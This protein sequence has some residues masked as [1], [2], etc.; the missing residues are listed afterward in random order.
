MIFRQKTSQLKWKRHFQE[1]LSIDTHSTAT[2]PPLVILKKIKFFF[3]KTHNF[4]F[5]KPP[6]F[7]RFEKSYYFRR[8]LRQ[9]CYNSV[10]KITVRK[11][12]IISN[13]GH[14]QLANIGLK[15]RSRWVDAFPSM[16]EM[17]AENNKKVGT[18]QIG[19]IWKAE[20]TRS[21]GRITKICFYIS[22]VWITALKA[23]MRK[24]PKTRKWLFSIFTEFGTLKL[25]FAWAKIYISA[26]VV[27]FINLV[28]LYYSF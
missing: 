19:E 8:I 22:W 7:E 24:Y 18:S 2:L 28:R 4:F 26:R 3:A 5:K 17:R 10:K 11:C 12:P 14:Y 23:I 21:S 25:N 9:I 27:L 16:F 15:N 6:N 13:I 20:N 1:I